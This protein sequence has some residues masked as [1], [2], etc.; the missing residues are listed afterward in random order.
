VNFAVNYSESAF[1]SPRDP[2]AK[3]LFSPTTHFREEPFF[4]TT[5]AL[6]ADF[7]QPHMLHLRL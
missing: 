7:S 4:V 2:Y 6:F 3:Q 5:I 1:C